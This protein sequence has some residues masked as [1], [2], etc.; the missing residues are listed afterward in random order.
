VS[1][2]PRRQSWRWGMAPGRRFLSAHH[3]TEGSCWMISARGRSPRQAR[4]AAKSVH[5]VTE[6]LRIDPAPR[7]E[8]NDPISILVSPIIGAAEDRGMP[9]IRLYVLPSR[10][11]A[12]CGQVV[13]VRCPAECLVLVCAGVQLLRLIAARVSQMVCNDA[14]KTWRC[15]LSE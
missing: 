1:R 3:W 7:D 2:P 4:P 12:P 14:C 5:F 11:G 10:L 8:E 6:G 9:P 15:S 13:R